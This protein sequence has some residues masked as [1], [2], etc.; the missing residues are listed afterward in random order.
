[1]KQ[2]TVLGPNLRVDADMYGLIPFLIYKDGA[3]SSPKPEIL[4][5]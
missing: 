2:K 4:F 5:V 1:M 3:D